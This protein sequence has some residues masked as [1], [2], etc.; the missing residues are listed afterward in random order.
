MKRIIFFIIML[1]SAADLYSQYSSV[2]FYIVAHSDQ[3]QKFMGTNVY[4]DI[5]TSTLRKRKKVVLIYMT[6]D[7]ESCNGTPLNIPRY[8]AK[9]QSANACVEF[10]SDQLGWHD[11]WESIV[12]TSTGHNILRYEYND[13][14]SYCLKLPG[15]C[16]GAGLYGTSLQ[17]LR[18]G[19]I[20]AISAVDS[21]AVYYG[22]DD[23]AKTIR[24]IVV[25]ESGI[26][27][28]PVIS[29][30]D[31]DLVINYGDHPD[32]ICTGYLAVGALNGLTNARLN[33]YREYCTADLPVNLSSG[34]IANEAALLSM[35]NYSLAESGLPSQW[36]DQGVRFTSRNYFRTI[37]K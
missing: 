2:S 9:Q 36:N 30:A 24:T 1:M 17:Q 34:E 5:S 37:K 35:L 22:W 18:T 7:D 28:E 25:N 11:T 26:I 8:Q 23:L 19:A 21:S 20:P 14:F 6:A 3:W 31:T 27:K 15:C 13:V 16:D 4:T 29:T 10:C 33:L 12:D 32:N